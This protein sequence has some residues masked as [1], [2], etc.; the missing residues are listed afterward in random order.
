MKKI[1]LLILVM[2]SIVSLYGQKDISDYPIPKNLK[3]CFNL[4]NKTTKKEIIQLIKTLPEDSIV[5]NKDIDYEMDFGFYWLG[6]NSKLRQYFNKK[7][8]FFGFEVEE[9]IL[10][11]YHRYLN[12]QAINLNQQIEK[13]KSIREK[14]LLEYNERQCNLQ[15][16]NQLN[17]MINSSITSYIIWKND[18]A[19]RG[20]SLLD[21]C[22]HYVCKDGLPADFPFDSIQNVTFFSLHN[23]NGLPKS[24]Q[25]ELKKGISAY[26]VWVK[27]TD[28]QFVI[29][30]GGR[31]VKLMKKNHIGIS[32][33]D[34]GIF[35][36]EYSCEKQKWLLVNADY[37]GI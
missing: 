29:T 18:F 31:G 3:Q 23:L 16:T 26:F 15:E 6:E 2:F 12:N 22:Q 13:Y 30:V 32:V 27:L 7:G 21:T 25:K 14:E 1:F 5:S 11:S 19:K 33:S 10:I 36:Y 28:K 8:L 4:L 35:T 24:F 20:I 17:K 37:G 9:S 34:W